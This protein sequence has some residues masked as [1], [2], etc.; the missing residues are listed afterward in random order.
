MLEVAPW[1]GASINDED[2]DAPVRS[3]TFGANH[4]GMV[5]YLVLEDQRRV[6]ILDVLWVGRR[7]APARRRDLGGSTEVGGEV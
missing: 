2:P 3:V 6:D 4:E 7:R 5:T 1:G